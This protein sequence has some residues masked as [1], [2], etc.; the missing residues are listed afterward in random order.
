MQTGSMQPPV[1]GQQVAPMQS[2][3]SMWQMP[4]EGQAG[5][6]QAPA[7]GEGPSATASE[8]VA[9]PAVPARTLLTLGP[10]EFVLSVSAPRYRLVELGRA[11]PARLPRGAV[12]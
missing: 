9:R 2:A 8:L 12:G 11:V 1:A 5:T 7:V 3:A 6:W 10:A 4:P